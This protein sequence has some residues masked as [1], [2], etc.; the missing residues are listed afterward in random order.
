MNR[1]MVRSEMGVALRCPR[2][3]TTF[4]HDHLAARAAASSRLLI[5]GITPRSGPL[6]PFAA[7]IGLVDLDDAAQQT[8]F[9]L[10]HATDTLAEEPSGLLPDAEVLGELHRRD[11][12]ARCGEQ[13]ESGEPCA[14]RQMRA[15]KGCAVQDGELVATGGATPIMSP[16]DAMRP[17][18]N[19]APRADGTLASE[20]LQGAPSSSR[21]PGNVLE[22]SVATWP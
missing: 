21:H 11:P 4:G 14:Q 8:V 9:V 6:A 20:P 22:K 7:E 19:T 18:D 12:F 16:T 17:A 1:T 13:I 10:H 15:F 2:A 5:V 3:T